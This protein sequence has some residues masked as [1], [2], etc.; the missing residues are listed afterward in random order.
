MRREIVT[1]RREC[2]MFYIFFFRFFSR[3]LPNKLSRYNVASSYVL[4]TLHDTRRDTRNDCKFIKQMHFSSA[5]L[6]LWNI[7]RTR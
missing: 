1:N 6:H 3:I 2:L 7:Y 4:C 5:S